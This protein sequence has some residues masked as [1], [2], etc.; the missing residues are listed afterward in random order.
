MVQWY[1][2]FR[3]FLLFFIVS[4][5]KWN[6]VIFGPHSSLGWRKKAIF[7]VL[8]RTT[9]ERISSYTWSFEGLVGKLSPKLAKSGIPTDQSILLQ[10]ERISLSVIVASMCSC[11]AT[12]W[13]NM[14]CHTVRAQLSHAFLDLARHSSSHRSIT[15]RWQ[16]SHWRFLYWKATKK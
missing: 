4:W 1:Y 3:N 16:F 5:G 15:E 2:L 10:I 14:S 8:N 7:F 13:I 11:F 6:R 12:S 9:K